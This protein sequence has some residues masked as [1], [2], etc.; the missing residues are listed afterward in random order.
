MLFINIWLYGFSS[1]AAYDNNRGIYESASAI[2]T[3]IR[4]AF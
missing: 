3:G 1:D 4:V 2:V